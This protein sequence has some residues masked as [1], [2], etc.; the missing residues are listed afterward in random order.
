[1]IEL[2]DTM[3]FAT[4]LALLGLTALPL[5]CGRR[6]VS[7]PTIYVVAGALIVALPIPWFVFD[8]LRSDW[9]L[10]IVE[11]LTEII[12][13][14]ALAAAGLAVDT[15]AGRTEWQHAWALLGITMP[16][17]IVALAALGLWAGLGLASALLLAAAMAP[18]DPVLARE[19]QVDGPTEGE[20]DDVRLSLTT[21]SGLNDGLAF[22]FVWLAILVAEVGLS[23]SILGDWVLRDLFWRIAAAL[24]VGCGVGWCVGTF[25]LSRWGDRATGGRNAGLVFLGAT[26]L[27]YGATEA[28]DGYGFLAVF[29][30]SRVGRGVGRGDSGDAYVIKPHEI[31]EQFERILLAVLLLWL[32]GFAVSGLMAETRWSEVAI[33]V[34]LTFVV[35]PVAGWIGLICT[36][37]TRFERLTIAFFGI[38]GMGSFFYI[39]YAAAH[40]EF[41]QIDSVWRIAVIA[42]LISIF[43]HG[44]LAPI[45]MQR[46]PN[47][48]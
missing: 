39:A 36:R 13:I 30:A 41:A 16:L 33:A 35:R 27:A 5:V 20:E 3:F 19:V 32:G 37:G 2:K 8:P 12:V 15:R 31:G 44:M 40:A 47:R 6:L 26:F 29:L 22:P 23:W 7:V 11:H 38:R 21:E 48:R 34:A 17:T 46:L 24:A 4:G 45:V 28:I 25:T 10:A 42:V 43:V 14:V 1:M 9:E 18:T